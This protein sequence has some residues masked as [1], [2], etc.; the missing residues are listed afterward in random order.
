MMYKIVGT[1][2]QC[3]ELAH[4][5]AAVGF[6]GRTYAHAQQHGDAQCG[7]GDPRLETDGSRYISQALEGMECK[8][9]RPRDSVGTIT[10]PDS[11]WKS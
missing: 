4:G 10:T 1:Y 6:A 9:K 7:T 11:Q 8:E 3:K 2:V 5:C